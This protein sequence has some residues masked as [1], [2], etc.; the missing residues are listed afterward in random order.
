MLRAFRQPTFRLAISGLLVGLVAAAILAV[1]IV[2]FVYGRR[3]AKELSAQV[4]DQTLRRIDLRLQ[5]F[6]RGPV[7]QSHL[8]KRWLEAG[9]VSGFPACTVQFAQ[10]L[11]QQP[12]LTNFGLGLEA[13]GEFLMVSRKPEGL[14]AVEYLRQA[15]G[16]MKVD[17]WRP[18]GRA[19][20][21]LG[22]KPFD[23]YDPRM[24]PWYQHVVATGEP[25]WTEAYLFF[26]AGGG[27]RVPGVTYAV[28]IRGPDGSRTAVTFADLSLAS[29]SQFLDDL[30]REIIGFAFVVEER[31]SGEHRVVA[32]PE[33]STLLRETVGED[34]RRETVLAASVEEMGDP[35]VRSFL[36][37]LN[38]RAE[39]A[40]ERSPTFD[41]VHDGQEYYGAYRVLKGDGVPRWVTGIM[42][43]RDAIMGAVE[44]NN[45]TAL[46]IGIAAFAVAILLSVLL[47]SRVS[48]P[49]ARTAA[50]CEAIGRFELDLPR[51][52][53]SSIVEIDRLMS[54]TEEMKVGL[55]SFERYVPS[56]LVKEMFEAGVEAELGGES[57]RLTVYFSHVVGFQDLMTRMPAEALVER[58]GAYLA[59][60]TEVI[61]TSDGT[62]DKYMG[63]KVMAFWGAPQRL[64]DH[65]RRA[66]RAAWDAAKRAA[67][68]RE[69]WFGGVRGPVRVVAG[70]NTGELVV[71]NMGSKSRLGYTAMGDAVNVAARLGGL[72]EVYG[73]SILVGEETH[74]V[75]ED[76]FLAR[77]VDRVA[78]KGRRQGLGVYELIAPRDEATSGDEAR[79]T[80]YEAALRQYRERRF[81]EATAAFDAVLQG[82]PDDGPS[83]VLRDR[84]RR[85]VV[86]PPDASWNGVHVMTRK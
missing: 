73:T 68:M 74:A 29:V 85:Y 64:D 33:P 27:G 35:R 20:D 36:E 5:S 65:A 67:A 69:G 16:S 40:T 26:G 62:L 58:L 8:T 77:L 2:S 44:R 63:D 39:S 48:T 28:P 61:E 51:L 30:R 1:G 15:D 83:R 86:D 32:H 66:C 17:L 59:E 10:T 18:N 60:M 54:A 82:W 24:R 45:R 34:G 6:F 25:S 55:R 70:I 21:H 47:A 80:A 72:N 22:D 79:V 78:V 9:V 49:L 75:V 81:E 53:H 11:E 4:L 41:L 42:V 7:R 13:T 14:Q 57:R 23:G 71:G 56:R 50:Q 38:A 3:S 37:A 19:R 46:W 52:G 84:C 76:D 43:P 12:A 31:A